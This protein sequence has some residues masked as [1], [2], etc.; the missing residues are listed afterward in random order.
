MTF[1]EVD[2]ALAAVA[3]ESTRVD[4]VVYFSATQQMVAAIAGAIVPGVLSD[5]S[6]DH[7][8]FDETVE[9]SVKYARAI[10]ELVAKR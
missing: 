10:V 5:P 8:G 6:L 3:E 4:P 9:L 7:L 1:D 2:E